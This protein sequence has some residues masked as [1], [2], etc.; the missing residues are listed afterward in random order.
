VLEKRVGSRVW[1]WPPFIFLLQ[2]QQ[3][4]P[5]Y[6][7]PTFYAIYQASLNEVGD[8]HTIVRSAGTAIPIEI[9]LRAARADDLGMNMHSGWF[10][11]DREIVRTFAAE[12]GTGQCRFG[13]GVI[14]CFLSS[15]TTV[16][17]LAVVVVTLCIAC[18]CSIWVRLVAYH[19]G[20]ARVHS[21]FVVYI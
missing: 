11:P 21:G 1:L 13:E 10:A 9:H 3:S 17:A 7:S 6:I 12:G 20:T 8:R 2:A 5:A 14:D 4:I 18:V 19:C 15:I 16:E